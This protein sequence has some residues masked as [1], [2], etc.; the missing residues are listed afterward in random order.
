MRTWSIITSI[1]HLLD[2]R[3]YPQEV[4]FGPF[5]L[6]TKDCMQLWQ[7]LAFCKSSKGSSAS[8]KGGIKL[9]SLLVDSW[10]MGIDSAKLELWNYSLPKTLPILRLLVFI[11]VSILLSLT[12]SWTMVCFRRRHLILQQ[13]PI[14]E[15]VELW[16]SSS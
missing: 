6:Y 15:E 16:G 1:Q 12:V 9:G 14:L 7:F 3:F 2:N 11:A 5:R 10:R 13:E 8:Y 4:V